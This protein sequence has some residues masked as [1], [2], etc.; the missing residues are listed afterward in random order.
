MNATT[1]SIIGALDGLDVAWGADREA[2]DLTRSELMAAI[3]AMGQLR[4]CADALQAQLAAAIA[5]E[6]RPEFGSDGLAK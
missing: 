5:D 2:G 4:R 3:Q 1:A 6:S